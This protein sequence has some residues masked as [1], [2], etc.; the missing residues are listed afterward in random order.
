MCTGWASASGAFWAACSTREERGVLLGSGRSNGRKDVGFTLR[1]QLW[2]N[3]QHDD[4]NWASAH[5]VGPPTAWV[6]HLQ[7]SYKIPSW[8]HVQ[9]LSSQEEL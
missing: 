2:V 8:P 4:V 1:I 9:V 3:F 6:L 7:G 5:C